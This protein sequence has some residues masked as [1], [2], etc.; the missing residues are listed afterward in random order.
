MCED[1]MC[2]DRVFLCLCANMD[3]K[4]WAQFSIH[5]VCMALSDHEQ[6]LINISKNLPSMTLA[7]YID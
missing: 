2:E 4:I 5:P 1:A 6:L 3:D 7:L